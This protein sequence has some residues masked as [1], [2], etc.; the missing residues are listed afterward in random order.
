EASL[1]EAH[2]PSSYGHG[3]ARYPEVT[4]ALAALRPR[5]VWDAGCG[6]G[7]GTFTLAPT[8][9]EVVETTPSPWELLMA[10]RRGRPHDR[11]RTRAAPRRPR[12]LERR[13]PRARTGRL[14]ALTAADG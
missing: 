6:T 13:T 3:F 5:R 1:F 9:G 2:D 12:G 4:D 7:E 11:A 14:R 10:R 8:A